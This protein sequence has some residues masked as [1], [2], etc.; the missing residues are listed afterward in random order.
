MGNAAGDIA[1]PMVVINLKRI[2]QKLSQSVPENW[3][4]GRSEN[5]WMTGETFFENFANVFYPWLVQNKIEF[6]VIVFCDGHSSHLTMA[7]SDFC[8]ENLIELVALYPNAT[9]ILQPM[10]D[11]AVFHPLKVSWK[12]AVFSFRIRNA[13]LPLR[14]DNFC[15]ILNDAL[16]SQIS[17]KMD[18]AVVDFSLLTPMH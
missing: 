4:I 2:P 6:P 8:K 13:G 16:K 10:D 12:K 18:F 9:Q 15:P 11:V 14:R 3:A 1:P 17:L 7:L 5:G